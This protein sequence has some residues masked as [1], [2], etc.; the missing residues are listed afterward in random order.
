MKAKALLNLIGEFLEILL[1]RIH[2]EKGSMKAYKSYERKGRRDYQRMNGVHLRKDQCVPESSLLVL[3]NCH[4][5]NEA[6]KRLDGP[7]HPDEYVKRIACIWN[8][9]EDFNIGA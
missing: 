9:Y 1:G 3:R 4:S 7:A 2:L 6:V 5:F 8:Y